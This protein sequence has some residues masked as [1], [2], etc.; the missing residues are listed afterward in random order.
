MLNDIAILRLSENVELKRNIQIACLPPNKS[1]SYPKHNVDT[2]AIGWG[3][4]DEND[5]Y[6]AESLQNVKFTIY[7]SSMC[8]GVSVDAIKDWNK[9]ICAGNICKIR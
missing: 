4:L 9:Q 7:N 8:S 5:N 6:V 3:L 1:S 2:W